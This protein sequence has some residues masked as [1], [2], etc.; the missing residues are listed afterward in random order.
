MLW[1]WDRSVDV[2]RR[3][4]L[5]GIGVAV[6]LGL[7]AQ[8]TTGA[9]AVDDDRFTSD[10]GEIEDATLTASRFE[11]AILVQSEVTPVAPGIELTSVTRLDERGWLEADVLVAE[12]GNES[13]DAG[14]L[15]PGLTAVKLSRISL[16]VSSRSLALTVT[17]SISEIRTR[18]S[19]LRSV[20]VPSTRVR[21]P[22]TRTRSASAG[23][24]S[25]DWH[26]S[27]LRV[28][29]HSLMVITRSQR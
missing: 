1:D 16:R 23:T 4:Y 22:V 15:S 17:S 25:L 20:R 19:V 11:D 14:L 21:P 10:L 7:A 5:K 18:P 27:H 6:S 8:T 29:F 13:T 24:V 26:E 12:M 2:S 28:P 3:N 9:V